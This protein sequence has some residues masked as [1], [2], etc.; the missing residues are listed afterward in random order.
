[1][2]IKGHVFFWRISECD[3]SRILS[4]TSRMS[5]TAWVDEERRKYTEE[6]TLA[7]SKV[8]LELKEEKESKALMKKEMDSGSS[9][10]SMAQQTFQNRDS[11]LVETKKRL[12]DSES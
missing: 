10:L 2:N 4:Q 1:M 7:K 12:Q 8:E 11:T 9:S 5:C 6:A 3:R